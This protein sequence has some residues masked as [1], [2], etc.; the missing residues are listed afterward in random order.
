MSFPAQICLTNTGNTQ[1]G[2]V[3]YAYSDVDGYSSVFNNNVLLADIIESSCPYTLEV[4]DNTSTVLLKDISTGCCVY[5]P[6][7]STIDLCIICDIGFN[8]Y[9]ANT[10]SVISVGNLTGSC[11]NNITDYKVNW[12]GPNSSTNIQFTSGKG[13]NFTYDWGHP[14]TG[15][16]SVFA[17]P[18]VYVPEVESVILNGA[19]L[20]ENEGALSD[21]FLPITVT[22]F[23]CSNGTNPISNYSHVLEFSNSS[24]GSIPAALTAEF[25]LSSTTNYFAYAYKAETISDT[26]KITYSGSNYDVPLV[27]EYIT[28]GDL[29]GSL[30]NNFD[31]NVYPKSG[32][33]VDYFAKVL[34]LTGI[35]YANGDKLII[36]IEPNPTNELTDWTLYFSCLETFECEKC[37]DSYAPYKIFENTITGVTGSCN[38]INIFFTLSACTTNQNNIDL[39]NYMTTQGVGETNFYD[40]RVNL[41]SETGTIPSVIQ[42]LFN[43]SVLCQSQSIYNKPNICYDDNYSIYYRSWI[44]SPSTRELEF[45]FEDISDFTAYTSNFTEAIASSG[46]SNPLEI[47]YYRRMT[48]VVPLITNAGDICGDN[49]Q[50]RFMTLHPASVIFTTGTTFDAPFNYK[51]N[52][53]ATTIT[54]QINLDSCLINCNST[55]N[56]FVNSI[57]NTIQNSF[58]DFTGTTT[59]S[60][61]YQ[62][63]FTNVSQVS[64]ADTVLNTGFTYGQLSLA[65]YSNLTYVASG[66]PL[67]NITNLSAQTCNLSTTMSTR[68]Q[69]GFVKLNQYVF[70]YAFI[71]TNP[72]DVRDFRI[73]ASPI[74]NGAYNGYPNNPIFSDFVYG[75]SGGGV[76]HADYTYLI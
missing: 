58:F 31:D 47:Q 24:Q 10:V 34:C 70:Y 38:T 13:T 62:Y 53:T 76:Y 39:I 71:L 23:N 12:Y 30:A 19:T 29:P 72:S 68:D 49:T 73:Y 7:D 65:E 57:N 33:S 48:L 69:Y 51:I 40:L 43:N 9:S 42:Q 41:D 32:D 25:N 18:G 22:P 27:I 11:E 26:L 17:P 3:F 37:F 46:S 74:I 52:I 1:L 50:Y 56:S 66:D 54:N 59:V 64:S 15:T 35:S 28:L 8:E 44:T 5:I 75:F 63:P 16:S 2:P 45:K 55:V 60:L 36:Q 20:Q 4:P 61:R 21:C 14:L 67:V 6:L